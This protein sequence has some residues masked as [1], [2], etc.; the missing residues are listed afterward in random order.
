M[1]YRFIGGEAVPDVKG[2]KVKEGKYQPSFPPVV[3][4]LYKWC[5]A[6]ERV[7]EFVPPQ[8]FGIVGDNGHIERVCKECGK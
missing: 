7:T 1:R 5:K 8:D 2:M 3:T 6:C 4:H